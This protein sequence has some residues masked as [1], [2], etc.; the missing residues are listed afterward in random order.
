VASDVA[1]FRLYGDENMLK[2]GA[3]IGIVAQ[4]LAASRK[5]IWDI[6]SHGRNKTQPWEILTSVP[7]GVIDP[8]GRVIPLLDWHRGGA[9]KTEAEK[10]FASARA[11]I[12][13]VA[14]PSMGM[15]SADDAADP[16]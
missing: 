16:E 6:I 8:S 13:G 9:L 2:D 7:T 4:A 3:D 12:T 15:V 11:V 10:L 14:A 5:A 1:T